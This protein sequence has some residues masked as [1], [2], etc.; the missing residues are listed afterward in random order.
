MRS[1]QKKSSEKMTKQASR[2]NFRKY[3]Q[4]N[5]EAYF[6]TSYDK[7]QAKKRPSVPYGLKVHNYK[8]IIGQKFTKDNLMYLLEWDNYQLAE[9]SW[10]PRSILPK[11][12]ETIYMYPDVSHEA[13]TLV[14]RQFESAVQRS[15]ARSIK[16]RSVSTSSFTMTFPLD[17]FR[18][19]F[20]SSDSG[21]VYSIAN[22]NGF[23]RLPMSSG[24]W[25][26]ID[27]AYNRSQLT[28]PVCIEPKLYMRK[29]FKD[30]NGKFEW[31]KQPVEKVKVT[32]SC[33]LDRYSKTAE[34]TK[35]IEQADVKPLSTSPV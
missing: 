26:Y 8:R 10:E 4:T 20:G 35:P 7:M 30:I 27:K 14:A 25:Y 33:N 32:P 31:R 21:R 18:Y 29:V 34:T 23:S 6:D 9:S 28:F 16:Y 22:I 5:W 1:I 12:M 24:W 11:D 3:R 19:V 2:Y 15:L 13:L 17:L